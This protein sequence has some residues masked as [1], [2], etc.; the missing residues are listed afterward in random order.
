MC[1]DMPRRIQCPD[2]LT[3][4]DITINCGDHG[5]DNGTGFEV[6]RIRRG[7][8]LIKYL[9]KD[10]SIWLQDNRFSRDRDGLEVI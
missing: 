4:E 7:E 2:A 9:N 5:E 6:E 1:I 10:G 8:V 3:G